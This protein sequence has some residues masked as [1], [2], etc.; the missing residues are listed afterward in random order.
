MSRPLIHKELVE[1]IKDG[2][3]TETD[4]QEWE[5]KLCKRAAEEALRTMPQ[6]V[7]HLTKQSMYLQKLSRK[8]Y[9]DNPD[10]EPHKDLVRDII[11][12]ME[13][14]NPGDTYE[15]VLDKTKEK[16]RTVIKEKDKS[17]SGGPLT[18]ADLDDQV[19]AL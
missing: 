15:Q 14:E 7:D 2:S 19:G 12:Q 6:V 17:K 9:K 3:L 18:L 10:L 16:V 5:N 1:K 11:M 8:F 13:G 4:I